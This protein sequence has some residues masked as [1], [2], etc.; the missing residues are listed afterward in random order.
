MNRLLLKLAIMATVGGLLAANPTVAQILP[1]EKK[2]PSVKIIKGPAL[3]LALDNLAIIRWT[4]NTPGG[5]D[6]HFSVVY[7]GTNPKDLSQMAKSQIRINRSHPET[8]FRVRMGGL[9][10][11]TTYYY[12]VTSTESDGKIDGEK[13]PVSQFT[14]PG[15]G[16]RIVAYPQPGQPK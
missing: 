12:R 1:P 7:Y 3:E 4:T 10:P 16:E 9:K 8:I 15:P 5:T 2:A 11:R 14:T 6:V 13:S